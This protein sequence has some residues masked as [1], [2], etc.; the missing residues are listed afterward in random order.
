MITIIIVVITAV[1]HIV[2]R[3]SSFIINHHHRRQSSS[4][5]SSWSSLSSSSYCNVGCIAITYHSWC[6]LIWTQNK[7][8]QRT[9]MEILFIMFI[10][11]FSVTRGDSA[12]PRFRVSRF[13]EPQGAKVQIFAID[14]DNLCC[15]FEGSLFAVP[16]AP[17]T[18]VDPSHV[19]NTVS[20]SPANPHNVQISGSVVSS[21]SWSDAGRKHCRS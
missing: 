13:S 14:V 8:R 18:H 3:S 21:T 11:R 15:R 2:I 6:N 10:P 20:E 1:V 17:E 7:P 9:G 16:R 12:V 4:S 19:L 5:T